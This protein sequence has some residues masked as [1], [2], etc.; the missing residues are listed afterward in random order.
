MIRS[1][2]TISAKNVGFMPHESKLVILR[3]D[4]AQEKRPERTNNT[5]TLIGGKVVKKISNVLE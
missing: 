3:N 4:W 2:N 1:L 5:N